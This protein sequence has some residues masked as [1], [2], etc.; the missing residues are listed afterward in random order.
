MPV[1]SSFV[2]AVDTAVAVVFEDKFVQLLAGAVKDSEVPEHSGV[3]AF[4]KK[5]SQNREFCPNIEMANEK[6]NK[7]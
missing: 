1:A 3:P 4:S 6:L 2:V 7:S 5:L